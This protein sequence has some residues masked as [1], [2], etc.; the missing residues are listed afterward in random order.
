MKVFIIILLIFGCAAATVYIALQRIEVIP[1]GKDTLNGIKVIGVIV[2]DLK[3]DI[4]SI[5]LDKYTI[6]K[7]VVLKLRMA[8]ID[9]LP[10]EE[11]LQTFRTPYLSVDLNPQID[12]NFIIY[13]IS[14]NFK[15]K[16]FW[17]TNPNTLVASVTTWQHILVRTVDVHKEQSIKK[18]M[19]K[20]TISDGVDIFLK[21]Y[22]A[23]NS[24]R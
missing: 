6:Q 8:G 19:I 12:N 24:K 3:P 15:Q 2:E 4:I 7:D 5:D 20:D 17:G 18:Q 21:D 13:I 9:V 23:V 22:L 1:S 11:F 16:M 14:I 10:E